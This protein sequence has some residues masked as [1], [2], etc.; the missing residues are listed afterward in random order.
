MIINRREYQAGARANTAAYLTF[1][2]FPQMEHYGEYVLI[3]GGKIKGVNPSASEA[4]RIGA[5]AGARPYADMRI[6]PT[7]QSVTD[8]A[9]SRGPVRISLLAAA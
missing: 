5:E 2:A 3:H 9:A 8:Q 1:R 4:A 6:V 7:G